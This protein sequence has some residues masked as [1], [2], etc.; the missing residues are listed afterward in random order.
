[1]SSEEGEGEYQG[2]FKIHYKDKKIIEEDEMAQISAIFD[3]FD[4]GGRDRVEIEKLS[5]LLNLL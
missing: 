3:A 2:S 5:V 1:M 4:I